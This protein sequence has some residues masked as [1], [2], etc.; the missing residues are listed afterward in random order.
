M[1]GGLKRSWWTR[2]RAQRRAGWRARQKYRQQRRAWLRQTRR[3]WVVAAGVS[4]GVLAMIYAY[5]AWLPGDQQWIC[6]FVGGA[7]VMA[8]IALRQSP[9]GVVERW[10]EGAWGEEA[11]AKELSRLDLQ[12]WVVLNDLP[13]GR[14]NFDHVVVG[15]RGLFVLN[16]KWS[17]HELVVDA[18]ASRLTFANRFDPDLTWTDDRLLRQAKRDAAAL[19]KT[20][21][22]RTGQ[23]VWVQPVIV[24]W[25]K[26]PQLGCSVDGVAIVHG[27]EIVPRLTS[28]AATRPRGPKDVQAIAA[29]LAPGRRRAT[30]AAR[31]AGQEA[32]RSRLSG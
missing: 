14:Y 12:E 29:A 9:P 7:F 20:V 31:S 19:S 28:V 10:Q 15:D 18:D 26:F 2:R 1:G 21:R 16:S 27:A 5:F 30:P 23:R 8:I 11:T 32:A 25:G 24:W 13:N 22:E 4:V 17:A 6:G 3:V